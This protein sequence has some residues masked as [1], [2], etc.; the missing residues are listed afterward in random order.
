[1]K[2]FTV[3]AAGALLLACSA[4]YPRGELYFLGPQRAAAALVSSTK[5]SDPGLALY[6]DPRL[7]GVVESFYSEVAGRRRSSRIIL[8]QASVQDIPLPLAFA[9]AWGE[10]QFNVLALNRNPQSV[11]RGLFQLNSR[12]FPHV[13]LTDFY[14]PQV[15][16]RLGM[17]HLRFCLNQGESELVA[18]A[19]YNAGA[20][21]VRKGTPYTT[22]N[23]IARILEYRDKLADDFLRALA[24]RRAPVDVL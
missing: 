20:L 15:N 6:R 13:K 18:L 10:S 3:L 21:K 23:H 14:D 24:G 7:R 19:I 4:T 12:T 11:D 8:Q 5:A 22:L 2:K 16:A 17:K 1:M 9:L